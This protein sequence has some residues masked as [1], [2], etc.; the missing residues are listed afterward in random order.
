M[1]KRD[2]ARR[3]KCCWHSTTMMSVIES[4]KT[5][6]ERDLLENVDRRIEI[7]IDAQRDHLGP[8]RKE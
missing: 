3:E 7:S 5:E 8:D 4:E 6:G 2:K 1:S